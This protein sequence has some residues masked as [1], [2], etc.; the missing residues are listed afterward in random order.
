MVPCYAAAPMCRTFGFG[1]HASDNDAETL[2]RETQ[3]NIKGT[4][5]LAR[6][7]DVS[8]HRSHAWA[9]QHSKAAAAT[10]PIVLSTLQG[11]R[12]RP[13]TRCRGGMRPWHPTAKLRWIPHSLRRLHTALASLPVYAR[14][15]CLQHL[16]GRQPLARRMP[17][18]WIRMRSKQTGMR[19]LE[20]LACRSSTSNLSELLRIPS[21][22][23]KAERHVAHEESIESLQEHSV[24]S[25]GMK[26][27]QKS[28]K[29]LGARGGLHLPACETSS[30]L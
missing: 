11:S 12:S 28:F 20:K 26:R 13:S 14:S 25:A 19:S 29:M 10:K 9:T 27:F 30:F 15:I 21:A 2:E 4:K 5:A 3:K 7:H 23:V 24:R 17:A 6:N 8:A 22:Q 1:S 18:H 16:T